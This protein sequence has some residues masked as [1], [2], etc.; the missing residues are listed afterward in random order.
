MDR[1][2]IVSMGWTYLE[3][4]ALD[5]ASRTLGFDVGQ[6]AYAKKFG[7]K[8]VFLR[9]TGSCKMYVP[10]DRDDCER[11]TSKWGFK[12]SEK[13]FLFGGDERFLDDAARELL[14]RFDDACGG[15]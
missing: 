1:K 7:R 9:D 12:V 4:D 13:F 11:K 15:S 10:F 5:A 2:I 8:T 6:P 14:S 3:G